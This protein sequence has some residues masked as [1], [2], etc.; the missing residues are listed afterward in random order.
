MR[1]EVTDIKVLSRVLDEM[2]VEYKVLSERQADIFAKL[3]IS[4]LTLA[5]AQ[6]GC[7]LISLEERD[8]TL[9]SYYVSLVGGERHD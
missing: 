8:E 5:L 6:G 9:E 2:Q 3:P 7:E 4:K 1:V